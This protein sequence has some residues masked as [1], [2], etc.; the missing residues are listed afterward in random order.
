VEEQPL[1]TQQDFAKL[2][3]TLERVEGALA[4]V[5]HFKSAGRRMERFLAWRREA[6]RAVAGGKELPAVPV[7]GV[8]HKGTVY[9]AP[10]RRRQLQETGEPIVW[11]ETKNTPGGTHK[12]L[13]A[14][15]RQMPVYET[16]KEKNAARR[17][18]QARG[19]GR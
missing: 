1:P 12:E 19:D 7:L 14:I 4:G 18:R 2:E 13:M 11:P 3:E 16:V 10:S 5:P 17:L 8:K 6:M 15:L 9:I